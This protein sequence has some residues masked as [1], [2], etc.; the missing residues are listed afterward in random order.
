MPKKKT[1]K[2]LAKRVKITARGRLKRMKAFKSHIL[3]SKTR[4]RKRHLR[5][6]TIMDK[7]DEKKLIKL[8]PYAKK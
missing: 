1:L 3:T 6:S 2:A 7:V 8:L 5:R 4:K